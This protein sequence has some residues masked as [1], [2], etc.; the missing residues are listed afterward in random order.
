MFP[1]TFFPPSSMRSYAL[2]RMSVAAAT[3]VSLGAPAA[4]AA[5]KNQKAKVNATSRT[6]ITSVQ[7]S[8][9][10]NNSNT[11]QDGGKNS[12]QTARTRNTAS[13][14]VVSDI[15]ASSGNVVVIDQD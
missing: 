4:M 11:T 10:G 12:N 5:Q 14:V 1:A 6:T 15:D 7:G 9:A 8:F 3:I 13:S 2:I